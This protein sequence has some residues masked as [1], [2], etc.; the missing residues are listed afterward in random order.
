MK[1]LYLIRHAKSSWDDM[2]LDDIDRPLNQ[3]GKNDALL[4][5]EKLRSR[6]VVPERIIVSPAKRTRKT[7]K[8][9]VKTLGLPKELITN[10]EQLYLASPK[11]ILEI[12]HDLPNSVDQAMIIGHNPGITQIVNFLANE[13][14][15]NVPTSGSACILFDVKYWS[16]VRNN[17]KMGFFIYPKMFK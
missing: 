17:G 12:I 5:G 2:L 9:L 4:I 6:G 3:R 13:H 1:K 11:R 7:A 10:N 15:A 8:R 14:I 16:D